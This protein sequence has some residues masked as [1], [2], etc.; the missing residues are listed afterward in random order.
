MRIER[1]DSISAQALVAADFSFEIAEAAVP[2]FDGPGMPRV[3]AVAPRTKRYDSDASLSDA[4]ADAERLLLAAWHGEE[5]A[6][7]L[8]ATVSWNGCASIDDIAVSR[9]CR[10]AGVA[11]QLMD[12]AVAWAAALKL[13]AIRLETQSS[14]VAAC[15]FYARYGFVLGGSD[16]FLY[17]QLPGDVSADVALYWYLFLPAATT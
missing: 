9:R 6:G 15:R 12:S 10:R 2:P 7:Y 17:S 8:L 16:R 5:L 11:A 14:N 13:R 1:V 4:A 3:E